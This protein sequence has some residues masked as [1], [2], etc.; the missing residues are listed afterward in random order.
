[1]ILVVYL[2]N[3]SFHPVAVLTFLENSFRERGLN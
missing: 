2:G 3:G 1:M